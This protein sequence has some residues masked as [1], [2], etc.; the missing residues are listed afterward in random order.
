MEKMLTGLYIED[1]K[2]NIEL[3][4]A[5]FELY[6][7]KLLGLCEYPQSV[8]NFYEYIIENDVDFLLIDHELDKLHVSYKGIDVLKEI[9]KQDSNIYAVLLT[10]Y[11]LDNYKTE[12]EEY[13]FQLNKSELANISKMQELTAKIK[14][15]CGNRQ[16]NKDLAFMDTQNR[17]LQEILEQ[18]KDMKKK[19]Q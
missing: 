17:N 14:R 4:Q 7:L 16:E 9:R 1:E 10:N 2:K 11:P 18:L 19:E 6:G 5:R 15:A 8:E 13:D 3:M 12:L